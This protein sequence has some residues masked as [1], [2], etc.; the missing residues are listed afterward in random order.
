MP[1]Q[2]KQRRIL[3]VDDEPFVRV[4]LES[5]LTTAGYAVE[6]V[7][8]GAAALTRLAAGVFDLVVTDNKMPGMTGAELTQT[9]KARWPKLP[10]VL[11]TG[12]PPNEPVPG[13]GLVLH[14]LDDLR[15]LLPTIAMFLGR[16]PG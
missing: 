1:A 4:A 3:I 2:H 5:Y 13:L 8:S 9:I 16:P 10:V 15:L 11:F 7:G 12:S 14:K 6:A